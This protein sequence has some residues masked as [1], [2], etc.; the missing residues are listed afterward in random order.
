MKGLT[1]SVRPFLLKWWKGQQKEEHWPDPNAILWIPH[2]ALMYC[3]PSI[4]CFIRPTHRMDELK[5][6]HRSTWF[7]KLVDN[8]GILLYCIYVVWIQSWTRAFSNVFIPT[9]KVSP[10][11]VKNGFYPPSVKS[12]L[13]SRARSLYNIHRF[14]PL[15]HLVWFRRREPFLMRGQGLFNAV[16]NSALH[17]CNKSKQSTPSIWLSDCESPIWMFSSTGSYPTAPS[18][19]LSAGWG[20]SSRHT[21]DQGRGKQIVSLLAS[22]SDSLWSCVV[23][24]PAAELCWSGLQQDWTIQWVE[25]HPSLALLSKAGRIWLVKIKCLLLLTWPIVFDCVS[26]LSLLSPL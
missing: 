8:V 17:T 13:L 16:I 23:V 12:G 22:D 24:S 26:L 5:A 7:S 15:T 6:V 4:A 25:L 9:V 1:Q 19:R 20:N 14:A 3:I 2:W 21:W 18:R 11:S 10:K